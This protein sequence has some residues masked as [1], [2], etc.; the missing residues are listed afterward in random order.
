MPFADLI[1]ALL[2]PL[3]PW[4]G[5]WIFRRKGRIGLSYGYFLGGILAVL[6]LPWS[7]LAGLPLPAAQL[8]AALLGFTIFLQAQREGVPGVRRLAVGVGGASLFAGLLLARLRLPWQGVVHFW[9]GAALEALLWLVLSDLAY[10]WTRGGK[11]ELRIPLVGAAALGLGALAQGLLPPEA[12][13][14]PLLPALLGGLLLGLVALQQLK[15]LRDQGAWVEGR[16][17]GLRLALALIEK[18]R[19]AELPGL[20]LGLDSHQPMWLVDDR[21]RILESNGPLSQLV[22]LPRYRLRGYALDGLFQGGEWPVWATV[23]TQLLQFGSAS[24]PATQVSEDGTFRAVTVQAS[25]FDRGMALLW[26]ADPAPGTLAL[27]SGARPESG[28]EAVRRDRLNAL[29]ALGTA[30]D[31]LKA[32]APAGGLRQAAGRAEE[33]FRRLDPPRPP[34]GPTD[35]GSVLESLAS[36]LGRAL[37]SGAELAIRAE[38]LPLA[39]GPDLLTRLATHLAL[40]ALAR[41]GRASKLVVIL[42]AVDLGGRRYGLLH[43]EGDGRSTGHPRELFGQAWLRQAVAEAGGLLELAQDQRGPVPRIYLPVAGP[44]EPATDRLLAGRH[45][46]VVD[47]DPLVRA[48]LVDLVERHGGL[49]SAHED[50]SRFLRASRAEAPTDLL[51]LER[52]GQLERFQRA[53]RGF[54][55]SPL[56]T[57]V[58]GLG[59]PLPLDPGSL[60]LR[61]LGFLEKPFPPGAFLGAALALLREPG[62]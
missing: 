2:L 5:F 13:R 12:S 36:E 6:T 61:R 45:L 34:E 59:H 57:L 10:R 20:A 22:G 42:E 24:V 62:D 30:V 26:L 17:Q 44:A 35:G 15:W 23:R 14:L 39:C 19:P 27:R 31:H 40:H 60:G 50:L 49:A 11:L 4:L 8:G 29:L 9:G 55:K 3:P 28:D 48:S 32:E 37:P 25:A 21:G 18:D 38:T 54:Q 47:Q 51:V 56:P 43:V 52:T 7:R 46:T 16:G 58:V 41:G 53:L 33:A 1:A